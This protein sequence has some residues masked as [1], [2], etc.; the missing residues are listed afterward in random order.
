MGAISPFIPK[1]CFIKLATRSRT[2]A[3]THTHIQLEVGF[4]EINFSHSCLLQ[5]SI[6]L[7]FISFHIL[8][9]YDFLHSCISVRKQT[10]K[11]TF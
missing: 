9:F 7:E 10:I 11:H 8:T 6:C 2:R 4:A 5:E 1:V 3:H